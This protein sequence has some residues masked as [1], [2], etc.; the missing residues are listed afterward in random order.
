MQQFKIKKQKLKNRSRFILNLMTLPGH[1]QNYNSNWKYGR[2]LMEYQLIYIIDGEGMFETRKKKYKIKTGNVMLLF[3][4]QWHRYYPDQKTGWVEYYVG[5]KGSIID[6][7]LKCGF[8]DI[9]EPILNIGEDEFVIQLFRNIIE[10]IE[11]EK[12]GYQQEVS[13]IVMHLIGHI[14]KIK[15]NDHSC[16]FESGFTGR[17]AQALILTMEYFLFTLIFVSPL[18]GFC[19]FLSVILL[20]ICRTAGA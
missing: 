9:D 11:E 8:I 16:Y 20:L 17:Q 2:I 19:I 7:I 13:G 6:N 10:L 3:P 5:F 12:P 4:D 18:C 15:K 1:P 14:L